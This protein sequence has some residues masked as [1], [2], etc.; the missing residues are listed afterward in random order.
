MFVRYRALAALILWYQRYLFTFHTFVWQK[1]LWF[2]DWFIDWLSDWVI[3]LFIDWLID[4][5]TYRTKDSFDFQYVWNWSHSKVCYA[6]YTPI[7]IL[8]S[9]LGDRITITGGHFHSLCDINWRIAP[10]KVNKDTA[11]IVN[12][13]TLKITHAWYYNYNS[14]VVEFC[15]LIIYL[16]GLIGS[17]SLH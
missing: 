1:T 16:L 12:S 9:T 13:L 10:F 4:S 5:N 15:M 17:M 14:S 7:S 8:I 11:F 3:H 6:V 2:I